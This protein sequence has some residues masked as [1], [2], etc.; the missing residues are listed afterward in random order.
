MLS[1]NARWYTVVVMTP[2]RKSCSTPFP[3]RSSSMKAGNSVAMAACSSAME[4]EL[5]MTKRMSVFWA[6]MSGASSWHRPGNVEPG[7]STG[8]WQAAPH[9]ARASSALERMGC[10][11][12]F[13]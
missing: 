3:R 1:K 9:R 6:E 11:K 8:E 10:I 5:S 4:P 7:S 12:G 2:T 13:S